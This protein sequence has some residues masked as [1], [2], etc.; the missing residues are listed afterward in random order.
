MT[1]RLKYSLLAVVFLLGYTSL[2]FELIV[3]R[4]LINFVGSNTLITSVVMAFILLFLSVGYYFGSVVK[5][6]RRPVRTIMLNFAK[7]LIVWY[8][9]A[10]SYYLMEIY[11]YMLYLLGLH[12]S[13]GFVFVYAAAFLA[14][15]SVCLGFITSV[16]GRV[17]HRYDTDYTGRFM[18]VDTIGSVLGSLATTLVFM[19]LIGVA[20]TVIVLA[21]LTAAAALLLCR[22]K[23]WK[24]TAFL[25][26]MLLL[27][28]GAVNNEKLMNPEHTLIKDDAISRIA[29]EPADFD[30]SGK[31]QAK[32]MRINGSFSSK[33]AENE[34]LMFPYVRFIND[35][36]IKTLPKDAPRDILILG[37]G[38]FTIGLGDDFHN[39]TFLDIDKDLKDISEQKFLPNPLPD[40]QKFIAQDAYLF[41]L[42]TQQKYDLIVVDV[43][44]AVQ[45]IPM[46]FVTTDFFQKIKAHLKDNGIMVANIIT[47]PAFTN[48]FSRRIDNTLRLVFPQYLQRQVLRNYN[49]YQP[50]G[51]Q[52][53]NV[54]YVYYNRPADNGFY[55]LNRNAALYGQ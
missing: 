21:A 7:I 49:P 47:S 44:S 23:Q 41:M 16:A 52:L 31:P 8:I 51:E 27:F 15:P 53:A 3:L 43:Y 35:N 28:A 14:F 33:I 29:I 45:S 10:G 4:Q 36:F 25:S 37:A 1:D 18:A 48:E 50:D 54:E 11:F 9:I 13:L 32:I 40:N 2:A 6:A 30:A 5:F 38:G 34:E 26:V 17:L 20:A 19:P 55:S 22:R 42:K 24:E 39:Y 46:N 12:S